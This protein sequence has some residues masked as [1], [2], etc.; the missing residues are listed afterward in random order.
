MHNV[1][2]LI[3]FHAVKI[4]GGSISFKFMLG[5]FYNNYTELIL[6]RCLKNYTCFTLIHIHWF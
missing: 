5:I 6:I 1:Q 3:E 4:K 2:K